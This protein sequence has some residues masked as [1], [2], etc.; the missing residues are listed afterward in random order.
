MGVT[1]AKTRMMMVDEYGGTAGLITLEDLVEEIV[2][3]IADEYDLDEQ[4]EY[5]Y[6]DENHVQLSGAMNI[7]DAEEILGK[8]LPVGE[9]E[10]I[11]GM[12]MYCMGTIPQKGDHVQVHEM[13]FEIRAMKGSRVTKVIVTLNQRD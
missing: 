2:G 9:Y 6:I 12:L 5:H 1:S 7:R 13:D 3:E 4:P 10:T 11:G 8:E